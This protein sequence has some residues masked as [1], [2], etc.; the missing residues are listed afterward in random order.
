VTYVLSEH[1]FQMWLTDV[2]LSVMLSALLIEPMMI[3]VEVTRIDVCDASCASSFVV[4]V[5]PWMTYERVEAKRI[6]HIIV[7]NASSYCTLPPPRSPPPP[8]LPRA[9]RAP[10][11]PSAF[12]ASFR[13]TTS[14]NRLLPTI[15]CVLRL[16]AHVHASPH[17]P[18]LIRPLL[19]NR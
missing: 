12:V 10:R 6:V 17:T 9:P 4:V 13:H 7:D 14:P 16:N 5:L 19:N 8:T 3:I 18:L 15:V 1:S 2:G 11:L